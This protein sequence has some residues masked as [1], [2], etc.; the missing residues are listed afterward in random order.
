[1]RYFHTPIERTPT[2][3]ASDNDSDYT[4]ITYTILDAAHYNFN[5]PPSVTGHAV[6]VAAS[7]DTYT[8]TATSVNGTAFTF[9]STTGT[10]TP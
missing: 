8:A 5:P 4:G 1:M 2:A 3:Y 9:D 7:G 10:I 6:T